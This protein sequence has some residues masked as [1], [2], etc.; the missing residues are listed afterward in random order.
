MRDLI[1][2]LMAGGG[3]HLTRALM[4]L[5]HSRASLT[6]AIAD[7]HA[8]RPRVG[9]IAHRDAEPDGV[10][11]VELGGRLTGAAALRSMGI[12]VHSDGGAFVACA[13]NSAR[14][15]AP[16]SDQRRVWRRDRFPDDPGVAWRVSA[17]DALRDLARTASLVDVVASVDS[18]LHH[19]AISHRDATS[20]VA[21][22]PSRH[23]R[24]PSLIDA[25]AE[26]GGETH[27]RLALRAIG[28]AVESQVLIRG[29]GRVDLLVDGWLIVEI[30]SRA[31][32]GAP[33]DQDRDRL[34]DGNATIQ[35][36][37]TLRFM[38]MDVLQRPD[39][40][41]DVVEARLRSGRPSVRAF[42]SSPIRKALLL[43][44]RNS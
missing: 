32:H 36:Y 20:L 42:T 24:I 38:S 4:R 33:S 5:G 31:H 35:G 18:A 8:I 28:V 14:L 10:R 16:T 26:S 9:W 25:L 40:C 23:H 37:A 1:A 44:P 30:D 17:L 27:M 34:R 29:V 2:D 22:L 19:G 21:A 41:Q 7:G 39:W 13:P 43:Q 11:A 3:I 12:W 15:R 6:R